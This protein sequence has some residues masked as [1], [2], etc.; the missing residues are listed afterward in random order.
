MNIINKDNVILKIFKI[1]EELVLLSANSQWAATTSAT[2]PLAA[3][4]VHTLPSG[5]FSALSQSAC[6]AGVSILPHSTL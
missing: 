4:N 2:S 6:F 5:T 1:S 3:T